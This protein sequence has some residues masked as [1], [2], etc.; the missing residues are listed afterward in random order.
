MYIALFQQPGPHIFPPL[1][2]TKVKQPPKKKAMDPD[3][4]KAVL[5]L[6]LAC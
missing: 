1:I 4:W 5:V 6:K 3:I 2:W